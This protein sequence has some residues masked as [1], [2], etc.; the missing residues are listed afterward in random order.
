MGYPTPIEWTDAT[1]NPVGGCEIESPGCI[2][3]YAQK[4]AASPRLRNHPL[5]AGITREVKGKP[6]FNGILTRLP[7]DHKA[8]TWPLSWRGAREPKLGAG[9]PSMIFPDDMSDLFHPRRPTED[10]DRVVATLLLSGHIA[11]ILTKRAEGMARYFSDHAMGVRV[12]DAMDEITLSWRG[13]KLIGGGS[14]Q[15]LWY[16]I[17]AERQKEMF[18]RARHLRFLADAG[19]QIF[20]SMEP[21]L[22]RTVLPSWFGTVTPKP[23]IIVGGESGP[24]A[25]PMHPGWVREIRDQC[26]EMGLPFFF[27]QWGEFGRVAITK[28]E[29]A[30]PEPQHRGEHFEMEGDCVIVMR[31]MGKAH[32]GRRLD[33]VE[34]NAFPVVGC[35]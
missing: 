29:F 31:R 22:E 30:N 28:E 3:C 25:R 9:K 26:G 19:F 33:G 35:A 7:L 24:D 2:N 11:Q 13:R 34:H 10:I 4:L 6:V 20:V 18:E 23:W 17:S 16:G 21:L 12:R 1:W 15:N 5:Y 32:T 8:W 14:F 27:K